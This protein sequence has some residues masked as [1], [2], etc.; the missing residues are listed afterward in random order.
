MFK[1]SVFKVARAAKAAANEL[2]TEDSDPASEVASLLGADGK[3][4][5]PAPAPA[6]RRHARQHKFQSWLAS[7]I[8]S[9]IPVASAL[10]ALLFAV[11]G[12]LFAWNTISE[13]IDIRQG[14]T[15]A[16][17]PVLPVT[18][19]SLE[20]T[21]SAYE[22][23]LERGEAEGNPV[24][25][26]RARLGMGILFVGQGTGRRREACENFQLAEEALRE[27]ADHVSLMGAEYYAATKCSEEEAGVFGLPEIPGLSTSLFGDKRSE[28]EKLRLATADEQLGVG[29]IAF[30][31]GKVAA[32][33]QNWLLA[34]D[35][36]ESYGREEAGAAAEVREAANCAELEGE[37]P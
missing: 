30:G 10:T 18:P 33:C 7:W 27:T 14:A 36:Y 32:A 28:E 2:A 5:A 19:Y 20:R 25:T 24:I 29:Y 12:A 22:R 31:A 37:A 26:G 15:S 16:A 34:L 35:I 13:H 21:V 3:E 8:R 23:D 4:E 17:P 1:L 9:W 11:A 6:T